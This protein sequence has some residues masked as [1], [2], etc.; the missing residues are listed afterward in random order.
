LL[1]LDAKKRARATLAV[2]KPRKSV[3]KIIVLSSF[4][5][6]ATLA[7]YLIYV[8]ANGNKMYVSVPLGGWVFVSNGYCVPPLITGEYATF[9]CF[10]LSGRPSVTYVRLFIAKTQT[11]KIRGGDLY[12]A[13]D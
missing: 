8:R 13:F 11:V 5:L 1:P 2:S 7:V 12:L 10:S 4:C 3:R 9:D 6:L